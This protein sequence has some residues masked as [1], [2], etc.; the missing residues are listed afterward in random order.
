MIDERLIRDLADWIRAAPDAEEADRRAEAADAVLL[1]GATDEERAVIESMIEAAM[2]EEQTPAPPPAPAPTPPQS[3][4]RGELRSA[5][6][7][8]S[9]VEEHGEERDAVRREIEAMRTEARGSPL[10]FGRATAK[11]PAPEADTARLGLG[12]STSTASPFT[13]GAPRSGRSPFSRG[14]R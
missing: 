12:T 1:G 6:G 9:T 8:R 4:E 2:T 13:R 5:P 3:T 14:K 10:G 7:R 11:A